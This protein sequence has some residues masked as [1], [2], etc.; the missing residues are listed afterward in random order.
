MRWL[1]IDVLFFKIFEYI[2]LHN[3]QDSN[4]TLILY[5]Q[6]DLLFLHT[7]LLY[8]SNSYQ[9]SLRVLY[10]LQI[11]FSSQIFMFSERK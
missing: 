9:F 3:Q 6:L 4:V 2:S 7:I 10:L 5:S 1:F 8:I 11:A